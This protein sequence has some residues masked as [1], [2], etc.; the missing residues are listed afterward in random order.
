[1]LIMTPKIALN[2]ALIIA[3]AWTVSDSGEE[4]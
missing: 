3:L 4:V 1:M 2:L